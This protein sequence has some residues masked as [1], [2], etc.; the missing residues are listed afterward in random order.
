MQVPS[1]RR[2]QNIEAKDAH[3]SAQLHNVISQETLILVA[4]ENKTG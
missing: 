1:C 4:K 2:G 3:L